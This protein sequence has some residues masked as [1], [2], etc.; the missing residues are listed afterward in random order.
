[1]QGQL[2]GFDWIRQKLFYEVLKNQVL[3]LLYTKAKI[4]IS[5]LILIMELSVNFVCA[6][7]QINAR[8]ANCISANRQI[9]AQPVNCV[10]KDK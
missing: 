10:C 9:N 3:E 6:N 8:D 7:R 1:M 4:K 5:L 2:V